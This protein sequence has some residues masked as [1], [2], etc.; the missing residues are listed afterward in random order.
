[1]GLVVM[2]HSRPVR[3]ESPTPFQGRAP[4]ATGA[5]LSSQGRCRLGARGAALEHPCISLNVSS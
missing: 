3:L 5:A 4:G 2:V 1:M